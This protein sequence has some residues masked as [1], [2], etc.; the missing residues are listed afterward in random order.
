MRREKRDSE[1][2]DLW[3]MCYNHVQS[4]SLKLSL[5]YFKFVSGFLKWNPKL[6]LSPAQGLVHPWI[7]GGLPKKLRY[8]FLRSQET[9]STSYEE[10]GPV[11]QHFQ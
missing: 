9:T 4:I 3:N 8:T 7:L 11:S 10:T 1:V 6:R 5:I 2:S